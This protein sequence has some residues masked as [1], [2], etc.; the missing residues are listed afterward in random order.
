MGIQ[1]TRSDGK[2]RSIHDEL[3]GILIPTP[4]AA[5]LFKENGAICIVDRSV[6][7]SNGDSVIIYNESQGFQRITFSERVDNE[8]VWGV[9]L[10]RYFLPFLFVLLLKPPLLLL[11]QSGAYI[12]HFSSKE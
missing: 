3:L 5:F 9:A 1:F 4:P 2:I 6:S 11:R 8:Q 10:Y 7:P 12:Q